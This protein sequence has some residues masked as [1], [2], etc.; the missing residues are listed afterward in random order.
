[1]LDDRD[2]ALNAGANAYVCKTREDAGRQ[3]V[4]CVDELLGKVA[5][6]PDS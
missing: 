6:N 2:A 1:V 5:A 4:D 3:L